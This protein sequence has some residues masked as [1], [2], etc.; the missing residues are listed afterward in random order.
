MMYCC[1]RRGHARASGV[2]KSVR[3]R[4][5]TSSADELAHA[6]EVPERTAL[7][8]VAIARPAGQRLVSQ[9]ATARGASGPKPNSGTV[10][11]KI[12]TVGVPIAD[13]RCSGAESFVTITAHRPISSA[14]AS[15]ESA[16]GRVHRVRHGGARSPPPARDRPRHRRSTMRPASASA[17]RELRIVRPA[18]RAPTRCPARARSVAR[19]APTPRDRSSSS[20]TARS[21]APGASD[22]RISSAVGSRPLGRESSSSRAA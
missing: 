2:R 20:T 21:A 13:A 22:G 12:A 10:G 18:L 11:P 9:H 8:S 1:A 19:P 16:P 3:A 14:D 7:R 4:S 17:L 6:A 5:A 15:S